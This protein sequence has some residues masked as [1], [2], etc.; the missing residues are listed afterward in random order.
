L[1][2]ENRKIFR[3]KVKIYFPQSE[4]FSKIGGNLKQG[5]NASW[6]QRGWT[7]LYS[8]MNLALNEL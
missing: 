8:E 1:T 7:P 6:Y 2:D 5:G 3:E 4:N